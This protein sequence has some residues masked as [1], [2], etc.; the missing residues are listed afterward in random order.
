MWIYLTPQAFATTILFDQGHGQ[1]FL[2]QDE[3]ELGLSKLKSVFIKQGYDVIQ[4][5]SLLTSDILQG[6]DVVFISGAFSDFSLDEIQVIENFLYEGGKL[7]ITLHVGPLNGML[8]SRLNVNVSNVVVK[9]SQNL[10]D[11]NPL[12][13]RVEIINKHPIFESVASMN[14]YGSW[15]LKG[16][17]PDIDEL[18]Y[19][20]QQAWLDINRNNH[21]E[22]GEPIG[23]WSV[24]VAGILGKGEYV[25]FADDAIFQN[26]YLTD[27][28]LS[29]ANNL[30]IWLR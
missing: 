20:G 8:L 29:I 24:T 27:M 22:L 2:I 18:L 12:N 6:V 3:G 13:F 15:A 4:S 23:Q 21:R 17:S 10:I 19:T 25:V 9:E 28:N 11:H 16:M 1:R 30:A 14:F 26:Q 7:C 5:T